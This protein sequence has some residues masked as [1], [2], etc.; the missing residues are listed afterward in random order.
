VEFQGNFSFSGA[1]TT[2]SKVI[3]CA[4][5]IRGRHRGLPVAIDRA[6]VLPYEFK[7]KTEKGGQTSADSDPASI[8]V[9]PVQKDAITNGNTAPQVVGDN[10]SGNKGV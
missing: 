1:F 8:S 3:V 7:V 5:M 2:L 6:V 10:F 4:V 9:P